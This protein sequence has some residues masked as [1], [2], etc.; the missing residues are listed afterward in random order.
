MQQALPKDAPKALLV[1]QI[2]PPPFS[3]NAFIDKGFRG[4][5][6]SIKST[7]LTLTTLAKTFILLLV[8]NI[9]SNKRIII[10]LVG[11]ILFSIGNILFSIGTILLL[12]GN[13]ISCKRIILFLIGNILFLVGTIISSAGNIISS[14]RMVLFQRKSLFSIVFIR[15]LFTP[16]YRSRATFILSNLLT[17][18]NNNNL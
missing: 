16:D 11:T 14:E 7:L 17:V 1:A 9:I 6:N 4:F 5:E 8:G 2:T 13:I 12:V 10:S 15:P 3:L 18:P